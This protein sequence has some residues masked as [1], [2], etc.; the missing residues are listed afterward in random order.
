MVISFAEIESAIPANVAG[1]YEIRTRGG[2]CLKVGI[3][4]DLRERLCTHRA[5]RQSGLRLAAKGNWSDP[6]NVRSKSSILAKHL[7]FD[8][9][10]S[11]DYDLRSEVGR[12]AFLLEQCV[13][14]FEVFPSRAA[15]RIRETEREQ[16]GLFRYVG[17]VIAR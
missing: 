14:T 13:L 17:R 4:S 1:L 2:E 16:S 12:R 11:L 8:S 10:L 5:S 15:A 3:A 7:F 6:A 9:E